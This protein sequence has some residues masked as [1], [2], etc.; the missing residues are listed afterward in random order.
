MLPGVFL[1]S[2]GCKQQ[3]HSQSLNHSSLN[4][5]GASSAS[6]VSTGC[7]SLTTARWQ[8]LKAACFYGKMWKYV[9][10]NKCL[11]MWWQTDGQTGSAFKRRGQEDE[12]LHGRIQGHWETNLLR[13]LSREISFAAPRL[14][15]TNRPLGFCRNKE[16]AKKT[17]AMFRGK[18]GDRLLR[19]NHNMTNIPR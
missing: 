5:H 13:Q 6:R 14:P 3:F 18:S 8:I 11:W 19:M 10:Y 7:L 9:W 12:G 4:I 16:P 1:F 2:A 15:G 17:D